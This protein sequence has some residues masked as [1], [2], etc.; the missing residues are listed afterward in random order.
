[1]LSG[2]KV[3]FIFFPQGEGHIAQIQSQLSPWVLG[4]TGRVYRMGP[5]ASSPTVSGSFP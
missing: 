1:M 5:A 4:G 2:W 3:F